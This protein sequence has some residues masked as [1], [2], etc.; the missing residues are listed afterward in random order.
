MKK[1]ILLSALLFSAAAGYAQESR[2]DASISGFET[3]NPVVHGNSV[4]LTPTHTTGVLAA[5][6]FLLTPRSALEL[7]YSFAQYTNYYQYAGN[8]TFNPIHTRQ[9]DLSLGYVYGRSYKNYNPF[10]EGGVGG[11]V[12]SPIKDHGTDRLDAKQT[13]RRRRHVRR[14]SGV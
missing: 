1:T 2:Q 6:R 12:F 5:Y 9:Q 7:S 10:V 8:L 11:V 3:I 4:T 13:T 14:R